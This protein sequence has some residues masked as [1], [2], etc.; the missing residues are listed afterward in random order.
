MTLLLAFILQTHQIKQKKKIKEPT[1]EPP[2]VPPFEEL[3]VV[4]I[5]FEL[6]ELSQT[7]LYEVKSEEL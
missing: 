5:Q 7:Y 2:I 1:T 3:P 4:Y 6:L